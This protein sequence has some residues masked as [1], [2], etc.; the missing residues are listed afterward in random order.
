[1]RQGDLSL[2]FKAATTEIPNGFGPILKS[3]FMMWLHNPLR[4]WGNMP[5][6]SADSYR[7]SLRSS[8]A[9]R[10]TVLNPSI[11]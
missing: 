6:F 5:V 9:F 1:M 10:I 4:S 11:P 2:V 3:G 7:G 8:T